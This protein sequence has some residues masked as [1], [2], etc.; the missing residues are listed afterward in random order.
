MLDDFGALEPF[1]FK[2]RLKI[3]ASSMPIEEVETT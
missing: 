3:R 1:M 2:V